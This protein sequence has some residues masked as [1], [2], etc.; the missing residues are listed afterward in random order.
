MRKGAGRAAGRGPVPGAVT[1]HVSSIYRL[2]AALST[3]LLTLDSAEKSDLV[4][5]H[6]RQHNVRL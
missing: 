6:R 3:Q 4:L 5:T 1:D 2:A